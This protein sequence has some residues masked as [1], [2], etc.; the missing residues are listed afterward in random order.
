MEEMKT[1]HFFNTEIYKAY[2]LR[3]EKKLPHELKALYAAFGDLE[4]S[5]TLG[6]WSNSVRA[7]LP[8]NQRPKFDKQVVKVREQMNKAAKK[9]EDLKYL[10][11]QPPRT[12]DGTMPGNLTR[13]QVLKCARERPPSKGSRTLSPASLFR[14]RYVPSVKPGEQE[15][16]T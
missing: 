14:V 7:T 12:F 3:V 9:I 13:Q 11:K 1:E 15:C 6:E 10:A 5:V 2:R 8:R 4:D 16:W